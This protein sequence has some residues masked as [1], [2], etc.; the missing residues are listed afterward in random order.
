MERRRRRKSS[1]R[2]RRMSKTKRRRT[3]AAAAVVAA[4]TVRAATRPLAHLQAGSP[5]R[6][7]RNASSFLPSRSTMSNS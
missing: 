4:A 1:R 2:T 3:A 5:R 7:P 6:I